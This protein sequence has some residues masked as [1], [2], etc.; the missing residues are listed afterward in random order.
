MTPEAPSNWPPTTL[1]VAA[2][3]FEAANIVIQN[4]AE[5][6]VSERISGKPPW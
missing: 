5:Q 1:R 6:I 2:L 4:R 3:V